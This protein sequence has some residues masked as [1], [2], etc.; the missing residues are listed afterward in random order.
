MLSEKYLVIMKNIK[1]SE[2]KKREKKNNHALQNSG[3]PDHLLMHLLD[4]GFY[5][6]S[7]QGSLV[8]FRVHSFLKQCFERSSLDT[9]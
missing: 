3:R 9:I 6:V 1:H 8:S 7:R 5:M 4:K 2:K